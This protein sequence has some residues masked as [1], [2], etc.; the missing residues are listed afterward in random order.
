MAE[1]RSKGSGWGLFLLFWTMLLL[2]LGFL[3]CVVFYK[4]TAVYEETRPERTMDAL[5]AEMSEEDWRE[6]LA[7]SAGGVSEYEARPAPAASVNMRMRASSLTIIS[8]ER[9]KAKRSATAAIFRAVMRRRPS[10]R[11]T[12]APR[13]SARSGCFRISLTSASASAAANGKSTASRPRRSRTACRRSP[14]RS[15]RLT[16]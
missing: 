6:T 11:S 14:C 3:V 8:T 15:K 2:M 10:S 1:K 7:A 9:S 13:G 16:E 5:M 4:Y 12:R